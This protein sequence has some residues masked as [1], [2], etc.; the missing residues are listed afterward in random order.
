VSDS[1]YTISKSDLK[2]GKNNPNKPIN[3][4]GNSSINPSTL[5]SDISGVTIY[6][7][8][9]RYNDTSV[10]DICPLPRNSLTYEFQ[11]SSLYYKIPKG[12]IKPEHIAELV[13]R[14]GFDLQND[15][16]LKREYLGVA[17]PDFPNYL[18]LKLEALTLK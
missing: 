15:Y 12:K 9:L 3:R 17:K 10:V 4:I 2:S 6:L 14:Y 18:S 1:N 13:S 7:A 5:A 11:T 8:V 16:L